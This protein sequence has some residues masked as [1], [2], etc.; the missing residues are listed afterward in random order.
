DRQQAGIAH[1]IG[2]IS[3]FLIYITILIY[4]TTVMRGVSEEKTSRIAEIIISSV[5]PFQLM[6]GKIIGIGAVGLTQFLLWAML[7]VL[8]SAGVLFFLPQELIQMTC[9]APASGMK[10]AALDFS[11]VNLPLILCCFVFYFLFGYLFYASLFAA[12][13]SAVSDDAQ[14]TQ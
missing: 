13:G 3:S 4:G 9:D 5:K 14:D 10:Q 12:V 7:I 1:L 11:S 8:F 2:Y 6:L